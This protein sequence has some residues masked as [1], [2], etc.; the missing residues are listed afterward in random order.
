MKRTAALVSLIVFIFSLAPVMAQSESDSTYQGSSA[1]P[2]TSKSKQ[3]EAATRYSAPP[4]SSQKSDWRKRI[5]VGGYFGLSLG[6]VYSNVEIS[7]IVG[8]RITDDFSMGVG[9]IYRYYSYEA[10][11]FASGQ[12]QRY[13]FSNWGARIN[14]QYR[15]FNL[16]A[17]GAE[18][19]YITNDWLEGYDDLGNP[20]FDKKGVNILFVGG[21]ITQKVGGNAFMYLMAYY[22]VL[23]ETYSPYSDNIIWRI[24]VSAGF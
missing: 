6:S 16:I 20:V 13:S 11:N 10:F 17:L 2:P 15:L 12:N 23:Q 14:A 1:L 8:Y 4:P 22:D 21:G 9:I 3:S 24:G 19:Q 7:P 18:Y 5:Y